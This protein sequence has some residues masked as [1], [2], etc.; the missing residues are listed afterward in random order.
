[1]TA[2]RLT[3]TAISKAIRE[4]AETNIRIELADAGLPGLRL[5]VTQAGARSWVLGCRDTLGRARRFPLGEHPGLSISE[6]R[7]AARAMRQA[8]KAGADPIAERRRSRAVGE[9]ARQGEG[10]LKALLDLYGRPRTER[11]QAGPGASQK[12]WAASR[13]R[14]DVVFKA[15]LGQPLAAL[16]LSDFQMSADSYPSATSAAFAARTLRP[17]L[18]WAARQNFAPAELTALRAPAPP[19]R[20]K[21]VLSR[22]ELAALLPKLRASPRPHAAAM[23]F[24][25]L[26]LARREEV[27]RARWADVDLAART[28]TISTTK[29]DEPHTVPLSD[30]AAELL[31][32]IHAAGVPQRPKERRKPGEVPAAPLPLLP[33]KPNDPIFHTD[34]KT[35]LGNWDRETKALQGAS[36]TGGWH[37][38]D[39]RRTGATM[40]GDMGELPDIVEAALNHTAIHSP[41][42]ATYNRS[43]YRPQ[44]AAALQ[45]LADALD[46]IEQGGALIVPLRRGEAAEAGGQ[47]AAG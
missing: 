23:R 25:L 16:K 4:A 17:V 46:G 38:H 22:D 18:R 7:E 45:R 41:L 24:M 29:N 20:R 19:K 12:A 42:A 9:A 39:L 14:V 3:E 43:R 5:R 44:V 37:R 32:A 11:R 40:L 35:A 36:K 31:R 47:T 6:A 2:V 34:R 33:L 21:R 26:T 27:C 15:Q 28:W 10:T 13:K 1:M 8:V 30:Q